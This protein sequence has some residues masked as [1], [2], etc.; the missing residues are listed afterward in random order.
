MDRSLGGDGE[1]T[2]GE[3]KTMH[4]KAQRLW[5]K[6]AERS[7]ESDDGERRK[8]ESSLQSPSFPEHPWESRLWS[9]EDVDVSLSRHLCAYLY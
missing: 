9:T 6:L 7:R 1:Q 5:A 8:P 4:R 3:L 2:L